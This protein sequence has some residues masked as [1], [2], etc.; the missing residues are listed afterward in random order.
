MSTR[1][2]KTMG[3]AVK[4]ET[5][6]LPMLHNLGVTLFITVFLMVVLIFICLFVQSY[7]LPH[8]RTDTFRTI[9]KLY[10]TEKKVYLM[11]GFL[12]CLAL[13]VPTMWI[14]NLATNPKKFFLGGDSGKPYNPIPFYV[15]VSGVTIFIGIVL[16]TYCSV[17]S[18][19]AFFRKILDVALPG[20]LLIS[21]ICFLLIAFFSR[22]INYFRKYVE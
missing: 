13:C 14:A 1:K 3:P 18:P 2:T 22:L 19:Y 6:E 5:T 17:V 10:M 4:K 21:F 16:Y 8:A 20:I 11:M 15:M 7:N 9:F 12:V